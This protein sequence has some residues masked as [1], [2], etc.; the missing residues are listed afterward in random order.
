[1]SIKYGSQN[2][3]YFYPGTEI[4]INKLDIKEQNL[5][6]EAETLF[7]AQR[8]LELQVEPIVGNFTFKY[9]RDVHFYIFQ[10]LYDFA[11]EIRN[12]NISKGSTFFAPVQNIIPYATNIFDELKKENYLIGTCIDEFSSRAAYYMA[13]LNII[14]PFREGNGRAIR[15]FIRCLALNSNYILNW[16]ALNKDELL[17]A[18]IKSVI[19]TTHLTKC[20]I[21]AIE[22]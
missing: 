9:L 14:H 4:L 12:E 5:L 6:N 21:E 15:E 22:S 1:M 8:L 11:G 18:S 3:K 2:S 20:I 17:N 16:N 7:T 10:D 19:D 13:E